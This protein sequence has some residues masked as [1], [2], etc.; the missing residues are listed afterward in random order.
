M[1]AQLPLSSSHLVG[2]ALP[3]GQVLL[4]LLHDVLG[5]PP[6]HEGVR[7]PQP[8]R[9]LAQDGHRRGLRTAEVL[10][11]V[12]ARQL[13]QERVDRRARARAPGLFVEERQL[14]KVLARPHVLQDHGR[15]ARG[16][17]GEVD[18]HGTRADQVH[19]RPAVALRK[20]G[21]VRGE[22]PLRQAGGERFAVLLGKPLKKRDLRQ[23][24]CGTHVGFSPR[25]VHRGKR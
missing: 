24:L 6:G 16:R 2:E 3:P 9:H 15:R 23:K 1:N 11:Q 4:E 12:L 21:F 22:A 17:R 19:R 7:L 5:G 8:I 18:L 25:H 13:E 20:D 14:A 10:G